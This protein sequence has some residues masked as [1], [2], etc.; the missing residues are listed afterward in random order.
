M[1]KS[2]LASPT[3]YEKFVIFRIK[4]EI[5]QI[6]IRQHLKNITKIG[7]LDVVNVFNYEK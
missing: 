5:E 1:M 3:L 4:I 6:L 2:E 7:V